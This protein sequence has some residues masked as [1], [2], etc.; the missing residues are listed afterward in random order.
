MLPLHILLIAS[1]LVTLPAHAD[2]LVGRASVIDGDTLEIHG[3][4]IRLEGIDAPESSQPCT[5]RETGQNW[6]CG[7]RSALWLSDLIGAKPVTCISTGTDRYKRVLAHCSVGGQDVGSEMVR[8]GWAMAY[9][10]YST[11]YEPEEAEA[12][13]SGAGIWA[14]DFD[15]PWDWRRGKRKSPE[16]N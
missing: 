4:R 14:T 12:R 3:Q 8:N 5:H 10:R 16:T 15:P 6:R 13:K 9:V 11:R 7:Q 2:D 1:A